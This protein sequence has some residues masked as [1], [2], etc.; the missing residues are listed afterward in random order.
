MKLTE[1]QKNDRSA[2]A[3]FLVK[4]ENKPEQAR[5]Y[6]DSYVEY[7]EAQGNIEKNGSIVI[8]PRT[9]APVVNPYLAIRDRAFAR[10]EALHRVGIEV[11]GL[12]S[13]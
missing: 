12:W 9:Q 1:L 5:L 4:F 8:H 6:A 13:E 10:L 2:V 11:S 7:R 3:K